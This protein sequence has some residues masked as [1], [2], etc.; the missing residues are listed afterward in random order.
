VDTVTVERCT[1]TRGEIALRRR[2]SEF[3]VVSNGVFLMSSAGG[4]AS[5]RALVR[6]ALARCPRP[7][8]VL[9]GG[10]GL[11]YSLS[12]AV[13]D[14]RVRCVV[15]V[16]IEEA[17]LR[18]QRTHLGGLTGHAWRDPRVE[19]VHADLLA[20]LRSCDLRFDAVCLDIDNGP[21]WTVLPANAALYGADGLAAIAEVLAPDGVVT[22][23]SAHADEAFASRLAARFDDVG[24]LDLPAERG[25]PDRVYIARR[26]P[27]MCEDNSRT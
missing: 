14:S 9:I 13:A 27:V 19:L 15:V 23:W 7:A 26:R 21:G 24:V 8:Q 2:G 20:W 5:E 1:A 4:G 10:L 22:V 12:E 16:E 6:A 17:V 18:W 3:D 11:G 25:E